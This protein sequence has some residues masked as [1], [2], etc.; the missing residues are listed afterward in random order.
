[1]RCWIRSLSLS[2]LVA[3]PAAS[4]LAQEKG[5][6]AQDPKAEAMMAAYK[7][8]GAVTENHKILEPFIGE[9][10]TASK[11]WMDPGAPPI[12]CTGTA[13]AKSIFDGRFIQS[14]HRGTFMGEAFVGIATTGYD[15]LKQK[16][17]STYIENGSTAITWAEGTYDKA[18]KTFTFAGQ[19]DDPTAGAKVPF[20]FTEKLVDKDRIAF[21]WFETRDGKETRMMELTYTRK[22][23]GSAK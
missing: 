6:P 8:A 9:W 12:D 10:T 7:K 21:E 5:K 14:E 11:V 15:N 16:Y 13:S 18:T 23:T 1:M 2:F 17:V 4:V 3:L 20:R 19:M 22:A